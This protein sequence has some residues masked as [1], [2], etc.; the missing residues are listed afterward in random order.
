MNHPNLLI[1]NHDEPYLQNLKKVL[2]PKQYRLSELSTTADIEKFFQHEIPDL[3]LICSS[4]KHTTDG[5]KIVADI[6]RKSRHIPI[7]LLTRFS[8]EGRA[9]AAL[10]AGVTDYFKIPCPDETLL[11]S[12]ERLL[13]TGN[14]NTPVM[15]GASRY[16][17]CKGRSLIGESEPMREVISYLTKV[18]L[19][20]ST[21]LITGETGTGKELAAERIHCS[22]LRSLSPFVSINCAALPENLVESELFGFDRGA[23][24]GAVTSKKGKFEQ[25][26]G[27]TIF[28]DEIGDMSSFAQAKILRCIESKEIYPLG[29]NRVIPLDI[30]VIA[31]TNQ[32]PEDLMAAGKFR[33]DLYYRLNIARVNLPPLRDRKADIL[34][35]VTHAIQKLNPRFNRQVKGLTKAAMASLMQYDWPG[36]I[37]ELMNVLE[38]S[39]INLPLG[40]VEY[41]DLPKSILQQL[42]AAS[43]DTGTERSRILSA[44]LDTNW[45]KSTAAKK[46]EWSRM[47]LY[48]KMAKYKIVEKNR[49]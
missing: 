31:A 44:L 29:S 27:G 35:L 15:S 23:F 33:R 13:S 6:R 12:F 34:R 47:T 21:V 38:A 26:Q 18:A 36:N 10:R 14:G 48:R 39:F 25:A 8:S 41:M 30:R 45:N 3:V 24:T 9:I 49:R 40:P 28:L 22:S 7:I 32:E 20:D 5:L 37:R 46:L 4:S 19:T 42:K 43:T 17:V 2:R 16:K 11:D 1:I